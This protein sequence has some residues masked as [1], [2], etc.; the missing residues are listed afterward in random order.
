MSQW[1]SFAETLLAALNQQ[2]LVT[3]EQWSSKLP[4]NFPTIEKKRYENALRA[5]MSASSAP[6]SKFEEEDISTHLLADV[7]VAYAVE[8]K[9]T[10]L[11]PIIKRSFLQL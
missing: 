6:D 4:Q 11:A 5:P 1:K 9:E 7:L 2:Q 3:A 10:S 8:K